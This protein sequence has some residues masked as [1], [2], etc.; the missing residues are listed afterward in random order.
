MGLEL[1]ATEN[2]P[3]VDH[4]DV[5]L[6]GGQ[7]GEQISQCV[8]KMRVF[9]EFDKQEQDATKACGTFFGTS[10]HRAVFLNDVALPTRCVFK[11]KHLKVYVMDPERALEFELRRWA[12]PDNDQPKEI[13]LEIAVAH[14]WGMKK[15]GLKIQSRSLVQDLRYIRSDVGVH[16]DAINKVEG[17]F[18]Y[19]TKQSMYC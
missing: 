2:A 4:I 5:M 19:C 10:A 15:R 16:N 13:S 12:D 8:E 14:L 1:E 17:H 11:K 3:K 9:R 18:K 6:D 7:R